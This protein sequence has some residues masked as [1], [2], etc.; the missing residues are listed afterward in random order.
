MLKRKVLKISRKHRETSV[1]L[2][3]GENFSGS[4]HPPAPDM[5]HLVPPTALLLPNCLLP[6]T[7]WLYKIY[8]G[9]LNFL[10]VMTSY[11]WYV[12][13]GFL[14][15]SEQLLG[16]GTLTTRS[17]LVWSPLFLLWEH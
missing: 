2:I 3:P 11:T 12:F 6:S 9:D 10:L 17:G 8:L 13:E 15:E 16:K 7:S 4:G 5:G 1:T 14:E